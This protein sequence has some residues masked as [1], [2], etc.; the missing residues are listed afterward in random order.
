MHLSLTTPVLYGILLTLASSTNALRR[1]P[2]SGVAHLTESRRQ[3]SARA[4]SAANATTDASTTHP[5]KFTPEFVAFSNSIVSHT[6]KVKQLCNLC[7]LLGGLLG[8]GGSPSPSYGGG[9]PSGA[10]PGSGLTPDQVN[11][12]GN[13]IIGSLGNANG[14]IQSAGT[15]KSPTSSPASGSGYPTSGPGS[16]GGVPATSP[17][18]PNTPSSG[19]TPSSQTPGQ[20]YIPGSGTPSGQG[21]ASSPVNNCVCDP[22]TGKSLF[23]TPHNAATALQQAAAAIHSTSGPLNDALVHFPAPMQAKIRAAYAE[24]TASMD[25]LMGTKSKAGAFASQ[26]DKLVNRLAPLA[27]HSS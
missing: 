22:T 20:T 23:V 2:S 15:P 4:V 6:E 12:L 1:D 26:K 8:G 10:Y 21:G 19:G 24:V 13:Q 17:S 9:Y 7:G 18:S 25:S 16:S 14:A 3:V 11:G 5:F 27:K